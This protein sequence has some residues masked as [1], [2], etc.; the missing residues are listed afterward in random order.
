MC[1]VADSRHTDVIALAGWGDGAGCRSGLRS[2]RPA[3]PP[4]GDAARFPAC[5][6][7]GGADRMEGKA[8]FMRQDV[9]GATRQNAQGYVAWG[10][11]VNDLMMVPSP[12]HAKTTSAPFCHRSL[13]QFMRHIRS[14]G[15]RQFNLE[16]RLAQHGSGFADLVP[17]LAGRRPATGL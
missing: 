11:A 4:Q 8:Q 14:L 10:E 16:P 12:P 1:V 7:A 9:G 13:G 5:K 6:L 3:S 2:L 17:R 15:G